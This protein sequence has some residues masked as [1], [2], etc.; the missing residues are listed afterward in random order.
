MKM[1]WYISKMIKILFKLIITFRHIC[2]VTRPTFCILK[3]VILQ[4]LKIFQLNYEHRDLQYLYIYIYLLLHF[5]SYILILQNV[6]VEVEGYPIIC[7][8]Y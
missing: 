2:L 4:K 5:Y 7:I 6:R 1:F 8:L 3:M